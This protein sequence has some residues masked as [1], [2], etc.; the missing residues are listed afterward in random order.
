MRSRSSSVSKYFRDIW[1]AVSTT[2][3]GMRITLGYFFKPKVTMEYP[4]EKPEIPAGHRGKHIYI[5]EKCNLCKSCLNACPVNCIVIDALGRGRDNM[6]KSW[7]VDYSKCMFCNL[8]CEA[9]RSECLFLGEDYDM[10]S[11]EKSGC[12]INFAR[13]KTPGELEEFAEK[14]RQK[15]AERKARAEAAAKA[16]SDGNG[17]GK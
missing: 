6:K 13:N 2:E 12:I 10:A 17:D 15:E 9:C 14:F 11:A 1:K 3:K 5:E 16:D 7:S 8:C 4:E